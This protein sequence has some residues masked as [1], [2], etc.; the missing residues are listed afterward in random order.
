MSLGE[1]ND[2]REYVIGV[3]ND[4]REYVREGIFPWFRYDTCRISYKLQGKL[5]PI[6]G[7]PLECRRG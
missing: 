1:K 6:K 5:L 3:K 4:G 7:E 2:L